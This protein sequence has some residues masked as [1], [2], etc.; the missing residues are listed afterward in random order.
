MSTDLQYKFVK[1]DK[2]L[3]DFVDGIWMLHNLSDHPK[4]IVVVPD[5]RIDLFLS[6]S[7]DFPFRI[8]LVGLETKAKP[9]IIPPH[10]LDFVVSFNMLA[11]EYVF[12]STISGILNNAQH[13]PD[14]Y[15]GFCV[16]DLDDFE[17]FCN[18][19][20]AIVKTTLIRPLDRRKQRLFELLYATSGALSVK[21]LSEKV[22][23]DS[24]QINSYFNSRFGISLKSYCNI[25]RFRSCF[26]EIN[27][28]KL[29]PQGNFSDQ[30]HFIREVK[31]LSGVSPKELN[32]NKNDRFI[33]FSVLKF[34]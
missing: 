30:P 18:K 33:Q 4:E 13:L 34:K 31:K 19:V 5:G 25:L 3:N 29:Y 9:V 7:D 1:P 10:S 28:G 20:T 8:M 15:W 24:R 14:G 17:K 6:S 26:M 23:W 27:N 32:R 21:K 11:I 16:N 22:F 12:H 2:S